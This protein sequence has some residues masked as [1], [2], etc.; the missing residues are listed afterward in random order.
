[1]DKPPYDKDIMKAAIDTAV[2]ISPDTPWEPIAA[3]LQAERQAN[4]NEIDKWRDKWRVASFSLDADAAIGDDCRN[5]TKQIIGINA[6]WVDDDLRIL[7]HLA[8][9]AVRHNLTNGLN[10]ACRDA[11]DRLKEERR[12]KSDT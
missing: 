6:I 11:I 9:I 8:D 7:A 4:I 5:Y 12:T 2:S 10:Q 1:M 3:A